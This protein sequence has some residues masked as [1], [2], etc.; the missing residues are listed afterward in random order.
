MGPGE[1]KEDQK[2]I[3]VFEVSGPVDEKK[4]AEFNKELR[5]LLE[6]YKKEQGYSFVGTITRCEPP[7]VIA[8]TWDGCS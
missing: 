7:R 8:W 4:V 5:A 3:L 6:K 2:C 1:I